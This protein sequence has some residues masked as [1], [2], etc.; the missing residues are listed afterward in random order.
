MR[1]VPVEKARFEQTRD[2]MMLDDAEMALTLLAES[3]TAIVD[4]RRSPVQ[5][6]ESPDLMAEYASAASLIFDRED[7][8]AIARELE[9][10][11]R[12]HSVAA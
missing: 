5:P 4:P 12:E 3:R 9:L 2:V 11:L 6:N 8:E 1:P 10:A 7:A